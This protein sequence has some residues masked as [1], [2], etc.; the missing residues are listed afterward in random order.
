MAAQQVEAE[1]ES[2]AL[3]QAIASAK[4]AAEAEQVRAAAAGR[5]HAEDLKKQIAGNADTR[6]QA[7]QAQAEEAALLARANEDVDERARI[8][9]RA[10]GLTPQ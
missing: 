10:L 6:Q 5:L 8:A 3:E 1:R 2:A 9:L 4:A 7:R